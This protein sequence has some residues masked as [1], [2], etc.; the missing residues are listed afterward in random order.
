MT[1][2]LC[3]EV[4]E[5]PGRRLVHLV[6]YRADGPL[7]DLSV[8]LSLPEGKRASRVTLASPEHGDENVPFHEEAGRVTFDVSRLSVYEIAIVAMQDSGGGGF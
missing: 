1:E 2:G 6:N 8:G 7:R 4:T 5:Q 3:T